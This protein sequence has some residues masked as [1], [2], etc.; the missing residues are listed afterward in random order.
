M[1][2]HNADVFLPETNPVAA[3]KESFFDEKTRHKETIVSYAK[4]KVSGAL[5]V[6]IGVA[7]PIACNADAT[8]S[9]LAIPVGVYLMFSK[10]IIDIF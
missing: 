8:F 10:K 5:M 1:V 2:A 4:Q 6:V 7:A 9:L 3:Q